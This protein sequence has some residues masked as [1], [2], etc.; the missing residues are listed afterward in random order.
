M[1]GNIAYFIQSLETT[2]RVNYNNRNKEIL[3]EF[4]VFKSIN[5]YDSVETMVE[6]EKSQ[7]K[8]VKLDDGFSTYGT[9][10]NFLTKVNAFKYQI[11]NNIEYMCL[12]EDDVIVHDNFKSFVENLLPLTENYNMIRL[13]NLGEGYITSIAGAKNIIKH[14]YESGIIMNIDNQLRLSC[15]PEL[16]VNNTPFHLVV[17]TNE[18]DCLRTEQLKMD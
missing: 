1:E 10:A 9:L 17:N 18:G 15:G 13:F 7:L 4:A 6:F 3:P 5:G 16:F 11:E 8:F 14:I 2:E 12:I